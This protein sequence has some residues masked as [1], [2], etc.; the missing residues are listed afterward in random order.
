MYIDINI[1][2]RDF[3]PRNFILHLHPENRESQTCHWGFDA[4]HWRSYLHIQVDKISEHFKHDRDLNFL[5]YSSLS[6]YSDCRS[7]ARSLY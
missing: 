3:S 4:S 7:L 6:Y 5:L 1:L 2:A